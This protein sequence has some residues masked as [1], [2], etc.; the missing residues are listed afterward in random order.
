MKFKNC[1]DKHGNFKLQGFDPY[2]YDDSNPE[3]VEFYNALFEPWDSEYGSGN[4]NDE[5]SCCLGAFIHDSGFRW[6]SD[7][8]K[9]YYAEEM[10]RN[11][12]GSYPAV[13]M[14]R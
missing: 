12:K 3:Y 7:A 8:V 10:G 6:S 14:W 13:Y 1:F 9:L 2:R 5:T 11:T 4:L